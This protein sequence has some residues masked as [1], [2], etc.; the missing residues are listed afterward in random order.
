M[1]FDFYEDHHGCP[2]ENGLEGVLSENHEASKET[3]EVGGA[4]ADEGST[5]NS[6]GRNC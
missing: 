3:T 5:G 6:E 1:K 2:K 4:E